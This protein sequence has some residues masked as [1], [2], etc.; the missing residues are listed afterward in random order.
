MKSKLARL[1]VTLAIVCF[2]ALALAHG[3]ENE[4]GSSGSGGNES[5]LTI[6]KGPIAALSASS[7]TIGAYTF[8]INSATEFEDLL[9][10]HTTIDAFK[11]GD[12]A[13]AKGVQSGADL[14]ATEIELEDEEHP[15][16]HHSSSSSSN[17]DTIFSRCEFP[18]ME[19]V[20]RGIERAV[21]DALL[22]RNISSSVSV[23]TKLLNKE[24][25]SLISSTAAS[26]G[27]VVSSSNSSSDDLVTLSGSIE[28]QSCAGTVRVKVRIKGKNK[29]NGQKV[30]DTIVS[31]LSIAGIRLSKSTKK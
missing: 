19:L 13:K 14:I 1:V 12:F 17:D 15:S 26:N 28:Q 10:N 21:R 7:V 5:E 23:K 3:G 18:H 24:K 11:V 27:V 25:K 29:Q 6:V 22:D 20:R 31:N 16:G 30:E 2:P 9:G 4:G 8:V